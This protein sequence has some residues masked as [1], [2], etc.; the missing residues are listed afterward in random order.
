MKIQFNHLIFASVAIAFVVISVNAKN[1][2]QNPVANNQSSPASARMSY[3]KINIPISHIDAPEKSL[4]VTSTPMNTAVTKT[5]KVQGPANNTTAMT[6]I[7][8]TQ[9]VIIANVGTTT[10]NPTDG[11]GYLNIKNIINPAVLQDSNAGKNKCP[12]GYTITSNG[13]CTPR[14]VES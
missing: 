7:K 13:D 14:F 1:I 9:S 11:E 8:G 4:V 3:S 6:S 5:I 2:P 12:A 10:K